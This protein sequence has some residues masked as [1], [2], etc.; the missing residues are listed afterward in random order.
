M[1]RVLLACVLA[2][3]VAAPAAADVTLKQAMTGKGLGMSGASTSTQHFKGAKMR[4][5]VVISGTTRT[6]IFDLDAQK[7]YSFD[8][9]KKEADVWDMQEVGAAVGKST[10]PSR[11]TAT[12]TPLDQSKDIAGR[13][14][15][16]YQMSISMPA[17]MGGGDMAMTV[18][19]TGPVWIAKGAPGTADW[20]NFYRQAADKGFIFTDPRAAKGSPGQAKALTEMYRKLAELGGIAYESE[21]AIKIEGSGPM[22]GL[23]AKMGGVQTTSTVTEVIEGALD[24]ALFAVPAGYSLKERK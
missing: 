22:A 9:K 23:L 18:S 20:A 15:D 24:D 12:I 6:T 1:S 13:S 10:D 7:M 19:L 14:A 21:V 17:A 4:T 16:G 5:D 2:I 3:A 8:S 11:M